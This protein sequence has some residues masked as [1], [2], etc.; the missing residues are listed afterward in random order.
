[1]DRAK[2]R[3]GRSPLVRRAAY[4]ACAAGLAT[5]ALYATNRITN[6][7]APIERLTSATVELPANYQ[8]QTL[9]VEGSD[10]E[11]MG[12]PQYFEQGKNCVLATVDS[13]SL[14]LAG[15]LRLSCTDDLR[16][17]GGTVAADGSVTAIVGKDHGMW[18]PV[19]L[20]YRNPR[21]GAT[22]VGSVVMTFEDA[23]DT[24]PEWASADGTAW[25]Y[26]CA[27]SRGSRLLRISEA[28]GQVEANIAMPNDCRMLV[29]ADDDGFWMDAT[30]NSFAGRQPQLMNVG[31][32]AAKPK[33]IYT[34]SSNWILWLAADGHTVFL[35]EPGNPVGQRAPG[36]ILKFEG[37][38][39]RPVSAVSDHW[40]DPELFG[41]VVGNASVGY[42]YAT[43]RSVP[44]STV[45][46]FTNNDSNCW[47]WNIV[48]TTPSTGSPSVVARIRPPM[49]FNDMFDGGQV[50]LLGDSVYFYAPPNPEYVTG[51][52][53]SAEI[54]RLQT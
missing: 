41:G 13:T 22:R 8:F 54:Y 47:A 51:M 12:Y 50:V 42:W 36:S 26:D 43:Q 23:S 6:Q 32:D 48:H 53:E 25:L 49:S 27:T 10:L 9:T 4:V 52:K 44:C 20:E 15:N 46:N 37:T 14:R 16:N 24:R 3:D 28:T 35:D 19:R 2:K 11:V 38:D 40:L 31:L 30:A 1:M 34:A 21:T 45:R 18:A 33:V 29:A 7:S 39:P 17:Y 5:L